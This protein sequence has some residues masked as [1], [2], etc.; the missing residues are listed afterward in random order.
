MFTYWGDAYTLTQTG[1]LE[2]KKDEQAAAASHTEGEASSPSRA[3]QPPAKRAK[4]MDAQTGAAAATAA[5]AAN[6]EGGKAEGQN[7]GELEPLL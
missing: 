2:G 7:D 1:D 5:A 3:E 4:S 6:E